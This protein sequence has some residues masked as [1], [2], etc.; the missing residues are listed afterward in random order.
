ML[1]AH[2]RYDGDRSKPGKP[3]G[4]C[5]GCGRSMQRPLTYGPRSVIV[6]VTACPVFLLVTLAVE[7]KGSDLCAAVMSLSL[8]GFRWQF[9]IHVA[10][11]FHCVHRSNTLFGTN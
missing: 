5:T 2:Y 8:E 6:T 9:L 10:T 1:I 4:A 7:P 3:K 11:N